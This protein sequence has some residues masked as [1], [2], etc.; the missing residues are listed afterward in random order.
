MAPAG[1]QG[2]AR[3]HFADHQDKLEIARGA[4]RDLRSF[5][6]GHQATRLHSHSASGTDAAGAPAAV[7]MSQ[8]LAAQR[9]AGT[10]LR[11]AG[12][13]QRHAARGRTAT[14]V[15]RADKTE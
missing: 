2:L 7:A 1:K 11:P 9:L 14:T 5:E 12:G 15:C 3:R 13:V 4:G 10:P 6:Q 8:V